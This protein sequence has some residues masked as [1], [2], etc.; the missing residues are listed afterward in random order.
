[1]G[2]RLARMPAHFTIVSMSHALH[3]PGRHP[4]TAQGLVQTSSGTMAGLPASPTGPHTL[5]ADTSA[6][7]ACLG[8]HRLHL[9]KNVAPSNLSCTSL[10]WPAKSAW[11]LSQSSEWAKQGPARRR[12]GHLGQPR[13]GSTSS[14]VT[15]LH[16]GNHFNSWSPLSL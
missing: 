5:S 1:M 13:T 15:P 3:R 14:P 9:R 6:R 4:G 2:S 12:S 11:H 10:H 16:C 7:W 8:W